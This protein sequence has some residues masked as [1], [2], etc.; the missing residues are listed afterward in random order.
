MIELILVAV[1]T[2]ADIRAASQQHLM[3]LQTIRAKSNNSRVELLGGKESTM[4]AP[5]RGL[6]V[7]DYWFGLL[8]DSQRWLLT[9]KSPYKWAWKSQ[10]TWIE[11]KQRQLVSC[12]GEVFVEG[13]N[14]RRIVQRISTTKGIA[15]VTMDYDWVQ[16]KQKR[17]VPTKLTIARGKEFTTVT[18]GAYEEFGATAVVK[19]W[20]ER[21]TYAVDV[22]TSATTKGV[23]TTP[24]TEVSSGV[25]VGN[26]EQTMDVS[27]SDG[28]VGEGG[29]T[30]VPATL[31]LTTTRISW[32]KSLLSRAKLLHV[33][34]R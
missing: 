4:P 28:L 3:H 20:D 34:K 18:W 23:D 16:L 12:E 9:P 2:M 5:K 7:K 29:A 30:Q 15:T 17:L 8:R 11:G 33:N 24:S 27:A 25:G 1:I 13:A 32:W 14:I 22:R 6:Y 26:S 10:C 21:S 19:E 31:S